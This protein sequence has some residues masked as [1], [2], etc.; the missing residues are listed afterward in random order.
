[1]EEEN[2]KAWQHTAIQTVM[3]KSGRQAASCMKLEE[4]FLQFRNQLKHDPGKKVTFIINIV[5]K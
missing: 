2:I 5:M 4:Y 3:I 1:M